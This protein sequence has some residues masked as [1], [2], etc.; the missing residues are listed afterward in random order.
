MAPLIGL[1]PTCF[2]LPFHLVRSQR[3]YSGKTEY[4]MQ[5]LNCEATTTNPKFCSRSCSVSN[6]NRVSIKRKR[7]KQC[8]KCLNL[9]ESQKTYCSPCWKARARTFTSRLK[10]ETLTLGEMKRKGTSNFNSNY[11]HIRIMSRKIYLQSNKPQKCVICGYS[12][13]FDVC[14]IK[15]IA[16]YPLSTPVNIINDLSN[17]I[18]MCKNH[19]WE[20]DHGHLQ[21]T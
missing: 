14:H 3:G 18:A 15:A 8:K 16:S 17:L 4:Y 21:L 20:Y 13:H 2:Q 10:L 1:E 6:S 11:P 9:I 19:H 7:T 12:L 5:C